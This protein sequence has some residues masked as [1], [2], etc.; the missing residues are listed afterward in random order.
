M[1]TKHSKKAPPE[2]TSSWPPA[3]T[4]RRPCGAESWTQSSSSRTKLRPG[5]CTDQFGTRSARPHPLSRPHLIDT[6][7][8]PLAPHPAPDP[9]FKFKVEYL[10]LRAEP[11][12]QQEVRRQ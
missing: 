6:T 11:E 5:R 9:S 4:T 7:A 1:A 2:L 8:L 12:A 3:T 10:G